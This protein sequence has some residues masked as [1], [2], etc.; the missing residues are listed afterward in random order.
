MPRARTHGKECDE[1]GP[2]R[3][4][5]VG[6]RNPFGAFCRPRLA[7]FGA[8]ADSGEGGSF[9]VVARVLG[10]AEPAWARRAG[11]PV[12]SVEGARDS[13]AATRAGGAAASVASAV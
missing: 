2:P 3:W 5:P 13:R 8:L 11:G 12:G 10:G 4:Q 6:F 7:R 9:A 1:E